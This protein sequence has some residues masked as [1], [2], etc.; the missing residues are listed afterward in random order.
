[1]SARRYDAVVVGAG[2]NGLAAAAEIARRGGDVRV[3]EAEDEIGGGTRTRA[4]TL[5]G[6]VHDICSAIHPLVLASPFLRTLPL[7]DHGLEMVHP[8]IPLAHPLEGGTAVELHR[9]VDLTAESI[10]ADG[11]SYR[12]F[13]TP[14]ARHALDIISDVLGPL[15]PPRHPIAFA[16]FALRSSRSAE[17]LARSVFE[18][19]RARALLAGV[20][21]HSMLR[22]DRRPTAGIGMGLIMLAHAVG[23][24]AARGGSH[25][26]TRALAG[27]LIGAGGEVVTGE[28]VKSMAD[29]P[30]ARVVLF[31]LVPRSVLDIAG[32]R[33]PARYRRSLERYRYGPGVFKID[34]ALDHPIP[35]SAEGCRKA[36]TVHVG[37]TLEEIAAGERTVAAGRIAERPFVLVA[38]QSLFDPS[39]APAGKHTAWAYCHVP[40]GCD[41]DVTG[42]VER[43][44][45]RFAPGFGDSILARHVMTAVDM[46]RYNP[47][48]VGGDINGG[49]QDL[50]QWFTRPAAR[51]VPYTT[52]D[53]SIFLC[54]SATPPGGGVHGMCGYWAARAALR[55]LRRRRGRSPHR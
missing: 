11:D 27:V 46:E 54:S 7:S 38:Q 44:I 4:L 26:I 53:P 2:P 52:P 47:N 21:A 40:S 12:R 13:A 19:P 25:A 29:L 17:S 18:H 43:Q 24:P 32:S 15:R 14:L 16:P 23:W 5:P 33:F 1:M 55:R 35:W 8:E 49:R 31:D 50:R 39:R 30:P 42:L 37:G 20:A 28:R 45:E 48:Y 10:G 41:V 34:W 3:I 22:L 36:G 9:S 6:F 51:L